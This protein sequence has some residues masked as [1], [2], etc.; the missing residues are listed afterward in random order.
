MV[1]HDSTRQGKA[2]LYAKV[3]ACQ[4]LCKAWGDL[5]QHSRTV[6]ASKGGPP[7]SSPGCAALDR[8]ILGLIH[9]WAAL[10]VWY[11][12]YFG[13]AAFIAP[14]LNVFLFSQGYSARQIGMLAAA[15]PWLGAVAGNAL[16]SFA[17][18]LRR[19]R[20][21]ICMPWRC[22]SLLTCTAR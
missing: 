6:A 2:L 18:A 14:F 21:G 17:D 15:R 13:S 9:R 11:S 7:G 16:C 4:R 8:C 20:C 12:I 3:R 19:H 5:P 22:C 10:Q 1:S